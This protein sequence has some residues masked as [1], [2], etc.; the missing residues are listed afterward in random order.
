VFVAYK[1]IVCTLKRPSLKA[2]I[3]KVKKSKFG[4][5]DSRKRE[6]GSEIEIFV[7]YFS[8]AKLNQTIFL[9][10]NLEGLWLDGVISEIKQ[11]HTLR[12]HILVMYCIFNEIALIS[13][14]KASCLGNGFLTSNIS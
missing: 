11:L 7:R 6:L 12:M 5:I 8:A 10:H 4:K 2:K 9:H 14:T 13:I 3:G 1:N